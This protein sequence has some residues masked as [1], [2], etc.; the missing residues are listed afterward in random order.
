MSAVERSSAVCL[1]PEAYIRLVKAAENQYPPKFA[2]SYYPDR[3]KG[4]RKVERKSK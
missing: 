3:A 1:P 4:S 2:S